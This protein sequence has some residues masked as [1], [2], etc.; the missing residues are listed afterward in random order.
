[1]FV[2][3]S[4]TF[5][6]WFGAASSVAASHLWLAANGRNA[7]QVRMLIPGQT[8]E[9]AQKQQHYIGDLQSGKV[10]VRDRIWSGRVW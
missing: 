9:E 10:C 4:E 2:D 1:M 6:D 7:K 8:D 3:F 5:L